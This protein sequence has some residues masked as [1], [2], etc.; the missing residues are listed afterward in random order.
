MEQRSRG[1]R[2]A[3]VNR[4]TG[5]RGDRVKNDRRVA[6][7]PRDWIQAFGVGEKEHPPSPEPFHPRKEPA[8]KGN[9]CWGLGKCQAH[10]VETALPS[11]LPGT[12][13]TK[14]RSSS[15]NRR[16]SHPALATHHFRARPPLHAEENR[17]PMLL[18]PGTPRRCKGR[19]RRGDSDLRQR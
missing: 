3:S 18:I 17:H 19:T 12:L 5:D 4:G 7:T 14:R 11:D 8:P 1:E 9:G 13:D 15:E 16:L 10:D 2:G 6:L